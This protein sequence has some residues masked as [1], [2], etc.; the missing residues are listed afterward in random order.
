M[1]FPCGGFLSLLNELSR[2][3]P[4]SK[5]VYPP[6][7]P[8]IATLSFLLHPCGHHSFVYSMIH[9]FIINSLI[10]SLFTHYSHNQLLI[11]NSLIYSL[12][13]HSFI[14]PF[15]YS[16]FTT[17]SLLIIHTLIYSLSGGNCPGG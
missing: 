13:T 1:R 14:H 3:G 4:I 17:H 6:T 15:I 7:Y 16:L 5:A 2:G 9:S 12:F 11:N 8:N 10:Y